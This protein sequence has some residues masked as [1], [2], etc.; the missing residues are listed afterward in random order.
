MPELPEVETIVSGLQ[1]IVGR[2]ITA[3]DILDP[4][5]ELPA[6]EIIGKSIFT[7]RRR[8]KYIVLK[9]C[10][11]GS[12]VFHLRMS[13]R[14][15]LIRSKDEQKHSRLVIQLD[16]GEA[17]WFVNPRRLGTVWYVEN[18]F[19]Y[20]VGVDPLSRGFSARKLG[21]ITAKSRTA[22]KPLLMDQRKIAGLGNIYS[23]EALW[24]A[25]IDPRRP[26]WSLDE[27]EITR[28]HRAI[29]LILRQAIDSMGTT[30]GNTVSD[31]RNAYGDTG[32]FQER[33]EVYGREGAK[34][35]RCGEDILRIKQAGRSTYFCS[36]CQK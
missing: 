15:V 35:R 5:I 7:V 18:G 23:S 13:G 19:P 21:E 14:L 31:Y 22:I 26:A 27:K 17:I 34:C 12:I 11:E 33:L 36:S 6:Q 29:R 10:D 25:G 24:R 2:T 8:G 9:L 30:F 32:S 3:I 16:N 20:Q 1:Q 28:L 4:L